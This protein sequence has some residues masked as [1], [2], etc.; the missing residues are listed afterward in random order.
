[1]DSSRGGDGAVG[2][3]LKPEIRARADSM[4]FS[5]SASSIESDFASIF[6][7]KDSAESMFVK[8]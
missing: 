4:F 2:W 1:M 7:M 6:E 8:K 5:N 3:L